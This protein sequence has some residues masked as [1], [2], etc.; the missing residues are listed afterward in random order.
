MT[1]R[2]TQSDI[3][4]KG[5]RKVIS[6]EDLKAA[7]AKRAKKDAAKA[8][9]KGKRSQKRKVTAPEVEVEP[10]L[11][12]EVGPSIPKGKE[13]RGRKRK[14]T[15]LETEASSSVPKGKVARTGHKAAID[16]AVS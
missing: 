2:S 11:E 14:S 8:A 1:R 4:L 3:L 13:K 6:Y 9:N 12:V 7:R 16:T 15:I 10:G 5:T